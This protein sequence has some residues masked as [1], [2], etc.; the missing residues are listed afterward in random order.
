M[1]N[2]GDSCPSCRGRGWKFVSL[3]RSSASSGGVAERGLLNRA[4]TLCLA[5]AGTG[6]RSS[7][8]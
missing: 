3:R 7:G 6:G 5:C 4:R 2:G 8:S 1:A